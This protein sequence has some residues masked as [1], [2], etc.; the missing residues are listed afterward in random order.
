MERYCPVPEKYERRGTDI[1]RNP[2][3][4]A[5]KREGVNIPARVGGIRPRAVIHFP[6][7]AHPLGER[8]FNGGIEP[9][10]RF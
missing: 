8:I 10:T 1:P 5:D 6:V 3:G 4:R 9:H 2:R 7:A